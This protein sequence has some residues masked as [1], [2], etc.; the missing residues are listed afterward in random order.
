MP[1]SRRGKPPRKGEKRMSEKVKSLLSDKGKHLWSDK[2]KTPSRDK[3]PDPGGGKEAGPWRDKKPDPW[4][5]KDADPWRGK[6]AVPWGGKDAVPWGG[7]DAVPWGGKDAVPWGGKGPGPWRDANVYVHGE[8][9][10]VVLDRRT[11]EN[12]YYALAL[13]L[14]GVNWPEAAGRWARAGKTPMGYG[15]GVGETSPKNGEPRD[16]WWTDH[17]PKDIGPK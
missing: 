10:T 2:D 4:V 9:V 13:A 14:S 16:P 3:D 12:V 7:K 8:A 15:K 6:D 1:D 5:G 17:G 11:A